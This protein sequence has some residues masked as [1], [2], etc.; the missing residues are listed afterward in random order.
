[1]FDGPSQKIKIFRNKIAIERQ[2][3]SHILNKLIFLRFNSFEAIRTSKYSRLDWI[4]LTLTLTSIHYLHCDFE[5]WNRVKTT[6][7]DLVQEKNFLV[8]ITAMTLPR[9]I[10]HHKNKIDI[11]SLFLFVQYL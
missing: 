10:T 6:R 8:L 11:V 9:D 7:S 3:S 4:C 1:M 2:V 5:G